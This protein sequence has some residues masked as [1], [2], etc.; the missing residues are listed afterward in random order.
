MIGKV[1]QAGPATPSSSP[2]KSPASPATA[3]PAN[4]TAE[5]SGPT[6]GEFDVSLQRLGLEYV[7]ILY[8]H[9]L[10]DPRDSVLFEPLMKALESIKKGGKARFIGVS[11]HGKEQEVIRAA[12]EGKFYDVVLSGYNFRKSNLVALDAAIGEANQAGMGIIAMKT[13]AGKFFDRERTQPINTKAALK[14]AL[15]HPGIATAIPGMTS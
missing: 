2:P 14:W 9:D 12:I 11:T 1:L 6:P 4:F 3:T 15:C 8:L 5:T 10:L 13:M 7:D